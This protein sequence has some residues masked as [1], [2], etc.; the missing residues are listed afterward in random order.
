MAK[1][2]AAYRQLGRIVSSVKEDNFNEQSEKYITLFMPAMAKVP[3]QGHHIN[4]MMHILGYLKNHLSKSEKVE[5]LNWFEIYREQRVSRITP[6]M[7]LQHHFNNHK[8]NYIAEQYY[9]SPFPSKLML[10]GY[11]T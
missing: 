8:N 9:F 5:L 10:P 7:L 1:D 6:L 2:N 3:T 4:V 11:K